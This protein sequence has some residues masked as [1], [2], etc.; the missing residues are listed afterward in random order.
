MEG[1]KL[2]I[3]LGVAVGVTCLATPLVSRL[4]SAL[5]VVDR[6]N[7]RGVSGRA[8]MPLLGGLAVALGF[9]AGLLVALAFWVDVAATADPLK[10]LAL[11]GLLVLALG[12]VD[13][14]SGLGAWPKFLVQ[15]AAAAIAIRYGFRLGHLTDPIS[16]TTWQ[17]PE[18]L[19]WIA[20]TLWIVGITNALN[21]VDGLDG[22]ATGVGAIIGGTLT[23]IAWQAGEPVGICVGIALVGA[24]LGFLPFNFAPARIFLGDTGS[25]FIGYVLALLTLAGYQQKSL[26][27]FVVPLL[28]LAV[29]ILDTGLSIVRRIRRGAPIFSADRL[30]MHHRLLASEGSPRSAVLQFYFLTACFCLI[31]VS[32]TRLQGWAAALFLV[33]VALLTLR[34]LW[35]LDVFSRDKGELPMENE[36]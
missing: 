14:R 3:P 29:P 26:L 12:A 28:A 7:E 31:A 36:R 1:L 16:V 35:N 22:L 11:G 6:P 18:W 2:L 5:R 8:D 33:A 20:S 21:L 27:T 10:G 4:A 23:V 34:L 25:L 9:V 19:V 30:H 32:F 24:L 17:L 13:D 15:I